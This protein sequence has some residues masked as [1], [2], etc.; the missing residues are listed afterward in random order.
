MRLFRWAH[1][2]KAVNSPRLSE[3]TCLASWYCGR[4]ESTRRLCSPQCKIRTENSLLWWRC[5]AAS[6]RNVSCSPG[7]Q[8]PCRRMRR[9]RCAG[10]CSGRSCQDR[11]T[12][13]APAA[14][15]AACHAGQK[16]CAAVQTRRRACSR[17][18][19]ANCSL[20]GPRAPFGREPTSDRAARRRQEG[21]RRD[22]SCGTPGTAAVSEV[23]S[24]HADFGLARCMSA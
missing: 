16:R 21:G 2:G 17:S 23:H 8:R 10:L 11:P 7:R 5:R 13:L 4:L 15:S 12:T 1:A 14:D 19:R 3:D 20:E 18:V 22:G 9:G 24:C 6:R